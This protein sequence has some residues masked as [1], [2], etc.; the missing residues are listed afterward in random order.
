MEDED[1][2]MMT[3]VCM[4]AVEHFG[5]NQMVKA[6]EEL[7]ELSAAVLKYWIDPTDEHFE[8]VLEEYADVQIML[9]QL[10]ML[11]GLDCRVDSTIEVKLLYL[12]MKMEGKL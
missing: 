3:K 1:R 2:D 8:K 4:R 6:A 7:S 11:I 10:D 12:R 5:R 9:T